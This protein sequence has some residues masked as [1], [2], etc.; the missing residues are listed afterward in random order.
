MY[1]NYEKSKS[2]NWKEIKI[3]RIINTI[4]IGLIVIGTLIVQY[5]VPLHELFD[6]IKQTPLLI[7]AFLLT[8][9]VYI[10]LHELIHGIL[11]RCYSGISP[12]YGFSGPFIFAKSEAIFTK[13]AYI[14][15]TLA[16]MIVLG[17]ICSLLFFIT[18]GAG[19]WF[20][21]YVG[22]LNLYTSR[23]DLQA[24][25]LL[26]GLPSTYSIKDDGDSVHILKQTY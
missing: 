14:I 12:Q 7:L 4:T 9:F 2:L 13:S 15:I 11:M 22:V 3:P 20:A 5:L 23:G 6:L 24:V 10:V 1:S 19:I 16:P 17:V 21:L 25:I 8:T 26:K 18:S